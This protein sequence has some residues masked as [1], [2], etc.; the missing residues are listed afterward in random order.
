MEGSSY[1]RADVATSTGE[2]YFHLENIQDV[3]KYRQGVNR[4]ER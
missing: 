3:N 4:R 2:E 1:M